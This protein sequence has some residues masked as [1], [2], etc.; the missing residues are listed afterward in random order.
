MFLV[1]KLDF[2]EIAQYLLLCFCCPKNLP[3]SYKNSA[4]LSALRVSMAVGENSIILNVKENHMELKNKIINFENKISI[5]D[6]SYIINDKCI[7]DNVNL[8]IKK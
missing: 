3:S 8:E 1:K 6:L 5:V 7:L 2:N 4:N